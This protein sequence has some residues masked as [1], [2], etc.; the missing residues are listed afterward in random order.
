MFSARPHFIRS[1]SRAAQNITSSII[2]VFGTWSVCGDCVFESEPFV[3]IFISIVCF[4]WSYVSASRRSM[5]ENTAM[6]KK[7]ACDCVVKFFLLYLYNNAVRFQGFD[8]F[9][10]CIIIV[11][12]IHS[13]TLI[14]KLVAFNLSTPILVYD[15]H[16][17]KF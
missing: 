15:L 5:S 7:L 10:I 4:S 13:Y 1:I 6:M 8:L 2:F 14:L 16:E 12:N 11:A 3:K 17:N 9:E